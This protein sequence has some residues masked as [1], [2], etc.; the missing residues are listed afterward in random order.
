MTPKQ[1]KDE[2]E[3]M[4]VHQEG[5]EYKYLNL[6]DVKQLIADVCDTFVAEHWDEV[7]HTEEIAEGLKKALE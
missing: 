1:L 4:V 6:I 2:I 5:E 3:N 7:S